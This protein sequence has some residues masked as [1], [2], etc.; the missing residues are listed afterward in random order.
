[1]KKST[2]FWIFIGVVFLFNI[3]LYWIDYE[4]KYWD[5]PSSTKMQ[6]DHPYSY[7]ITIIMWLINGS[8]IAKLSMIYIPKFNAWLDKEK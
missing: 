8:V 3:N 4:L 1:M 7:S 5:V 2:K 6:Y